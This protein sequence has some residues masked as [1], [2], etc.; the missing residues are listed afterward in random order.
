MLAL[1]YIPHYTYNDYCAWEGRWELIDG[2]PYAMSPAPRIRHQDINTAIIHELRKNIRKCKKCKALIYVDWKINE[3]TVVQPDAIVICRNSG[4]E[5]FLDFPPEII[6]E[7][8]S[9][10]T[11]Y[12]DKMLKYEL[13]QSQGVKYY[14]IVDPDAETAEVFELKNKS[15]T[16][17]KE[18]TNEKFVFK[19]SECNISFDFKKI[20]V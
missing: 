2:I 15:Y 7:I 3:D 4:N 20:W 16:R 5:Q 9:P 13:Y 8:L 11:T 18:T 14:V 6:F 12:K 19:L 1:K 17:A 10:S